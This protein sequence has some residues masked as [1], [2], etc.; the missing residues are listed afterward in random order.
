VTLAVSHLGGSGSIHASPYLIFSGRRGTGPSFYPSTSVFTC[1]Y[2]FINAPYSIVVLVLISLDGDAHK[3]WETVDKALLFRMEHRTG[4]YCQVIF[5]FSEGHL[6][7]FMCYANK[8]TYEPQHET[9]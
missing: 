1:Q 9:L 4:T 3:A 2:H 7:V 6:N 5:R 8:L